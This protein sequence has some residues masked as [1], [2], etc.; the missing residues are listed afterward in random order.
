MDIILMYH[1][2]IK[3]DRQFDDVHYVRFKVFFLGGSRRI[4]D[5]GSPSPVPAIIAC[6]FQDKFFHKAHAFPVEMSYAPHMAI[7]LILTALKKTEYSVGSHENID[8]ACGPSSSNLL[9]II[10]RILIILFNLFSRTRL[11]EP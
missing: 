3:G 7:A 2:I 4:K 5:F 8:L 6:V 1:P 11:L 10:R 9:K